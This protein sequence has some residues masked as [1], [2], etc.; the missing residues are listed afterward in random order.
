MNIFF[1]NLD[2]SSDFCFDL[3]Q[4]NSDADPDY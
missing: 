1:S 3:P 2:G 4:D